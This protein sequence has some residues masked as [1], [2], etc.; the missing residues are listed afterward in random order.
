MRDSSP[1]VSRDF[2]LLIAGQTTSQLGAQVSAV[3]IPLLAVLVLHGSAFQLGVVNAAGTIAFAVFGL[4]VGAWTDRWRRRRI[5]VSSDLARAL[6]LASI[7]LAAV[8]GALTMTQLVVV[9]LLVGTARV[10]FDVAY[11]SYLPTLLGR[12]RVLSGNATM[13]TIR[14]TGQVA[15]PGLGGWLVAVIGAASVILV[16]AGTFAVSAIS[17]LAIRTREKVLPRPLD[18]L[19]LRTQIAEGL[20]YVL[21]HRLLRALALTSAAANTAFAIGSAVTV[22][23]LARTLHLSAA[24]IGGVLAAGSLAALAGAAVTPRLARRL[25][26]ARVVWLPVTVSGPLA[27]LGACAVPG[28][29]VLLVVVGTAAGELGQI[30]YAISGVSLRQRVCPERLLG[31][32]N[33]TMRVL[34]MGLFPLGALIGGALGELLGARLTLVVSF[35]VLA[36]SPIPVFRALRGVRDVEDLASAQLLSA[37]RR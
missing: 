15:G 25:G 13:E 27:L 22:I 32:V 20:R 18:R 14:A 5:L 23:F 33:A 1:L 30:V 4:P 2:R 35:A 6:L 8:L 28:W 31:R 16:Q 34:I 7:P 19:R 37:S 9:S 10:F 11:Q 3:A 12:D 29:P 21:A 36:L 26:S 24:A 17:I